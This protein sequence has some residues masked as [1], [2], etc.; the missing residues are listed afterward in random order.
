MDKVDRYRRA[1]S[2]TSC[3]NTAAYKPSYGEVEVETI[4]DPGPGPLPTDDRRMARS[5]SGSRLHPARGHQG[6]QDLDSAR[7]DRGRDRQSAGRGRGAEGR[8]RPGFPIPIQAQ[9]HGIRRRIARSHRESWSRRLGVA[10][11]ICRLHLADI[12]RRQRGAPMARRSKPSPS[13]GPG[14]RLAGPRAAAGQRPRSPGLAACAG[15]DRG[16]RPLLPRRLV[17]RAA[18]ADGAGSLCRAYA[19]QGDRAISQGADRPAGLA[20]RRAIQRRDVRGQHALLVRVPLRALGAGAGDRGRPDAQG[21]VRP[22][23][24]RARAPRDRRGTG[25]R[26]QFSPGPARPEPS[27]RHLPSSSLIATRSWAGPKTSRGSASTT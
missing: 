20:R 1:D 15:A 26:A 24:G 2:R 10:A 21:A 9:V 27:G 4:F 6:R 19:L 22:A 18:G 17:R 7:W 25:P 13:P 12:S 23:R 11:A 16:V 3:G 14:L 8:D 5:A